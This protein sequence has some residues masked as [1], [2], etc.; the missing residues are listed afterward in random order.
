MSS[1]INEIAFP[2]G[3]RVT[4]KISKKLIG[5]VV[6][7]DEGSGYFRYLVN[8]DDGTIAWCRASWLKSEVTE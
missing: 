6:R 8:F 5:G 3:S 2:I 4:R 7:K 1:K